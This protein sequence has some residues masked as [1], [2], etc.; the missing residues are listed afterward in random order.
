MTDN[1]AKHTGF[2]MQRLGKEYDLL[3]EKH[4]TILRKQDYSE[5]EIAAHYRAELKRMKDLRAEGYEGIIEF[6]SYF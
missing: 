4:R 5:Q 6:A 3:L 1:P 2:F